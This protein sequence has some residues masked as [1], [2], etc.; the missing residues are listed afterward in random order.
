MNSDSP[1]L[2]PEQ[3]PPAIDTPAAL[4]ADLQKRQR[5]KK[6]PVKIVVTIAVL[7]A[8]GVLLTGIYIV[9]M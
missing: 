5:R 7:I 9:L 2:D 1:D 8:L 4:W 6:N 3:N